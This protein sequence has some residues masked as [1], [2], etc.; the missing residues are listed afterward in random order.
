MGGMPGDPEVRFHTDTRN[1]GRGRK[2]S[3]TD[4]QNRGKFN[5]STWVFLCADDTEA[6]LASRA[7][8]CGDRRHIYG[9]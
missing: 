3:G 8:L 4:W 9:E 6:P 1:V 2:A 5:F 7:T